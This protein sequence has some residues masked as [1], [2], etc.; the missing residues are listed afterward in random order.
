MMHKI[1]PSV[2]YNYWLKCLDIELNIKTT[3]NSIKVPKV[4]DATNK[5]TLI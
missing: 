2:E 3:K 4:V 5:K 1:T